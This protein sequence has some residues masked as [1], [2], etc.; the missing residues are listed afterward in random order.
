MAERAA[1]ATNT[2]TKVQNGQVQ[3]HS[4]SNV[5]F[6]GHLLVEKLLGSI[7]LGLQKILSNEL[8]INF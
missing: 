1:A 6:H 2:D 3:V 8:F 7:G 4:G 5:V